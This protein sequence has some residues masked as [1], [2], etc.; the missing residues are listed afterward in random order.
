MAPCNLAAALLLVAA[1]LS[2]TSV[3]ALQNGFYSSSCPQAEATVRN[4]TETI[5]GRNHTMGA[6][7]MRLFFHDCF[8]RVMNAA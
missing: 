3:A 8:V 2:T 4:V 7:F 6:A 1:A 5:I